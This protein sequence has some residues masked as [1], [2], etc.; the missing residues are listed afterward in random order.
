[1]KKYMAL[2]LLALPI[3]LYAEGGEKG[4]KFNMNLTDEQ[5]TCLEAQGC[6]KGEKGEKRSPEARECMKNAFATCG[7]EKPEGGKRKK[8]KS[9]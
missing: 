1:M 5:K 9:E 6:P 7:I 4:K 8:D 2:A 3:A